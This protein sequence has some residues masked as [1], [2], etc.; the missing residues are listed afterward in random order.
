[1]TSYLPVMVDDHVEPTWDETRTLRRSNLVPRSNVW[2]DEKGFYVQLALP[3]WQAIQVEVTNLLLT[4]KGRE[5]A[6]TAQFSRVFQLPNFADYTRGR[7]A[8]RNG[9]LTVS[10]PKRE[11]AKPRRILVEVAQ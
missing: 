5:F 3:G 2:D 4:V 1:M 6:G 8:Y 10:F 11:E 7:A 9:L